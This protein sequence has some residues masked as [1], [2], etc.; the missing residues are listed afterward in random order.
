MVSFELI[1]VL[2]T[3][4]SKS[5][6]G[7]YQCSCGRV[8]ECGINQAH[9][10]KNTGCGCRGVADFDKDDLFYKLLSVW[11]G[12][13]QR[14]LGNDKNYGGRGIRVC[15]RWLDFSNFY[16]DM[17]DGYVVGL[18]IDRINVNGHYEPGNCRWITPAEN[19]RNTRKSGHN[20]TYVYNG[21]PTTI[22]ELV[23]IS[24]FSR[25]LITKRIDHYYWSVEDAVSKP[26]INILKDKEYVK[27]RKR[28]KAI[29]EREWRKS[30]G[31]SW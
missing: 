22:N 14:C 7:V 27:N 21:V 10:K 29:T 16:A 25:T 19:S 5:R 4:F 23:K 2:G 6:I 28:D 1:R 11:K 15:D 8:F 20:K 3:Q 24:G 31:I 9:G 26:K 30:K 13:K 12:I 17:R 18:H